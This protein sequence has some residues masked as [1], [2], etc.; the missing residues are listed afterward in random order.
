VDG[1]THAAT[2][3][4]LG[5]GV[6]VATRAGLPLDGLYGVV[7]GGLALLP[8]ADHPEASFAYSAGWVSHGVSAA[9]ARLSGGHRKG[10]HSLPV[11]AGW[12]LAVETLTTWL[13]SLAGLGIVAFF[14]ALCVTAAL[15]ATG[16]A[17]HGLAGLM[18][19]C[20]VAGWMVA[21][22]PGALWWLFGLG[23]GLHIAEDEFT[24]HGCS[25]LWPFTSRRFG[26][27]PGRRSGKGRR[28]ERH[29]G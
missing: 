10:M 7:T 8:D 4:I 19:G 6:G 14:L 22:D 29:S 21:A 16:F 9:V 15:V 5:A 24:G 2:G 11:L 23:M 12:M 17:W 25:L 26:G 13:P 18:A 28:D 1:A 27:I 3:V 20:A